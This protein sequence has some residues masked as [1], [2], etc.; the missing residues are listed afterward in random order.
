M[1]IERI[2]VRAFEYIE[3][4]RYAHVEGCVEMALSLAS[5]WAA[6]AEQAETAAL[7]HDCTKA[8]NCSEQLKLCKQYGIIPA[9]SDI[10]SPDTLHAITGAAFAGETFGIS[11]YV[12]SAIRWHTTGRANMSLLEKIIYVADL[13]EKT[14]EFG[15]VEIIRET[16]YEDIDSAVILAA[17]TTME[18]LMG[19]GVF[20][21]PRT[22]ETYNHYIGGNI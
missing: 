9:N 20:V 16:A 19:R 10:R 5:K 13:T 3:Q 18:Y 4:K 14:R 21:H 6:A 15:G 12:V 22:L 2:R 11:E 8:L 17:R 7:L 1:E